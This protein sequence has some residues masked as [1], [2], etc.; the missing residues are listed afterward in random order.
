M[1][2]F[3]EKFIYFVY[4]KTGSKVI[5]KLSRNTLLFVYFNYLTVKDFV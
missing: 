3:L 4:L 1:Y 2:K 5:N